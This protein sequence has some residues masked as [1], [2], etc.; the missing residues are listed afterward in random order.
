MSGD[1]RGLIFTKLNQ[2]IKRGKR[3]GYSLM[4]VPNKKGEIACVNIPYLI[5]VT[6]FILMGI[7]CYYLFRYPFRISEIWGLEC[8]I[9]DLRQIVSRQDKE[10]RRLDP[11][12][13]T[14]QEMEDALNGAN[15]FVV[16]MEQ[17]YGKLQNQKVKTE[18]LTYREVYLPGYQLSSTDR[19]ISKLEVLNR[20]L[21]YLE[22]ELALTG[23]DLAG[24]VTKYK[25]YNR[26]LDFTPTIWPL[27]RD[28]RI[29]SGFGYRRHPI[30]KEMMLHQG[31]DIPTR[32]G[33]AV[34]ATAEGKVTIAESR[35]GYGLL[36]EINHG[37]GFRTR[38]GHNS[39]L[40][41]KVG[42]TVKKGQ[43]IAYAGNTGTST[44]PHVHYEVRLNN[45]PVNPR[46][47][48]N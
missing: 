46:P 44:G 30:Y 21:N 25:S 48:L 45:V 7:N 19:D 13:K 26:Q 10:L 3:K 38:Y 31:I 34:R 20:N 28:R 43:V 24:L 15:G 35:G 29:S 39:R 11:C 27:A 6:F 14:T 9:Y 1:I 47:Y 8:H 42:Q 2:A 33:T 23:A 36:V 5:F 22:E 18:A 16:E 40:A 41:V 37:Y 17:E 32:T 12:L 4:I